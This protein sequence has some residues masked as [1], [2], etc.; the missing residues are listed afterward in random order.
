MHAVKVLYTF[1]DQNQSNCL[2]R[3]PNALNVPTVSLDGTT[4]VGVIGLRNC[5]QAIT[6]A[7]W[8]T[9]GAYCTLSLRAFY[10][11]HL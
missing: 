3:L 4:E 1:D 9:N 7:R 8:V 5:I 11:K 6:A 10:A 2:A